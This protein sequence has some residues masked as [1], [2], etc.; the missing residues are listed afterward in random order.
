MIENDLKILVSELRSESNET[1]WLEFKEN[2]A[3]ELGNI[4]LLFLILLVFMIKNMD[5]LFSE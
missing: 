2:N 5:I 1:E 4:F 3:S